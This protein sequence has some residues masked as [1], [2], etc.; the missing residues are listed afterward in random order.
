MKVSEIMEKKVD[1]V[2]PETPL[3]KVVKIIFGKKHSGLPV[4]DPKTKKLVGF[5]TDQDILS[6]CFPSIREYVEDVV[7]ARDFVAMENK[8]KLILELKVKNVMNKNVVYIGENE[9]LLKAESQ[10]KLRNV[11]R[12]PVVDNKKR[13]IGII[14]KREIFR[15]LVGK[16]F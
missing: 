16:Y 5:I 9:Y 3:R 15:A 14:T 8:L 6:R 7:H 4:V 10:M 12:L 2:T 1:F 13:L 11:A